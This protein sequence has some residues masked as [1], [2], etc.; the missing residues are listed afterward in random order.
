MDA[1]LEDLLCNDVKIKLAALERFQHRLRLKT[2]LSDVTVTIFI[3][4]LLYQHC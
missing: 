3:L 2:N 4:H 1:I